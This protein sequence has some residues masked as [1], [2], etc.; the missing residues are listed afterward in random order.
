[1]KD[2]YIATVDLGTS[3]IALSVARITGEDVQVLYYRETPSNGVRYGS[4]LNPE[5]A[6]KALRA[7]VSSAEEELGIKI[8]Q[9]VIGLPRCG[10][11]QEI[12]TASADR[13]EP[14]SCISQEEVDAIKNMALDS[15]PL[16]DEAEEEMYGA[17]A[18]SFSTEDAFNYSE[19]DVVGMPSRSLEGNFKV[20]VGH[21]RAIHNIDI[22]LDKAGVAEAAKYFLPLST[23]DAV[24]SPEE[25]ENGVALIEMGAGV[26]SLT[27]CQ[28]GILR[29]YCAIPFGG[30][31]ITTDIKYECGFT[32]VLAENIKMAFGACM[33]ERLLN[34]SEKTLQ[35]RDEEDGSSRQVT[36]KYLSEVV[37][38][39]VKEIV[40]AILYKIQESG[41]ED[42]LRNGIVLTGGGANL[43]NCGNL[44]K[45]MSGYNV[46]IGYPKI[47]RMTVSGCTGI[48]ETSA[49]AT[50]GMLMLASADTHIDCAS[51]KKGAAPAASL[52]KPASSA[53]KD[54]PVRE[55]LFD[56]NEVE[57]VE[58]E[59][60]PRQPRT[61]K[62]KGI[63]VWTK[64]K[65]TDIMGDLYDGMED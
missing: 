62:E 4:I 21:K 47:R 61:P 39:R 35:I 55:T 41:Y 20:F 54:S 52:R 45:Q 23:A 25:K 22:M 13:S 58:P 7:A 53:D 57:V 46:R 60:K 6:S 43:V 56:P 40:D 38:A 11:R 1:M 3:K 31:S 59:K 29:Y 36:V 48:T 44:I 14:N 27:I 16:E 64:K 33:P 37:T 32:E 9:V 42:K 2:R 5:K 30:R 19:S 12:A 63:F 65:L 51:E 8:R 50:V 24:L 26:T 28:D 15:Y 10:V 49:A 34:M 17:I 18:Q